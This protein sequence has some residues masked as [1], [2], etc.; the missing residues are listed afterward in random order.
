MQGHQQS[1]D[2][3]LLIPKKLMPLLNPEVRAGGNQ[4][5]EGVLL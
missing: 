4:V 2:V 1:S 3:G 5:K